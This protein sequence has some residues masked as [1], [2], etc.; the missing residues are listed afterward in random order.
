MKTSTLLF[1]SLVLTSVLLG[2]NVVS[3]QTYT[4]SNRIPLADKTLGTQVSGSNSNFNI[5]GGLQR[6][7][8]LFHSFGDFSVPTSGQ[9]NFINP[10]GNR[11]IITRVTG[12][13]FSDINGTV[14]TQGANFFLINPNGLVFGPNAQLNV[15]KAFVGSTANGIDLVDG[16]GRTVTFGTNPNGDAPLLS[17][18]PNVFFNVSRLNMGGGN[19]AISNFG[20][21]QTTNPNQYIGLIGGRVTMNGG[22]IEAPGGRVE[23]GGLSAPGTIGIGVEGN[24]LRLNFPTNIA[25]GDVFFSNQARVS[26][27]GAGGGDIAITARNLGILSGS[28]VRAGIETGL[29]TPEAVAG[30]I[31]LNATGDIVVAGSGSA[32]ANNVR[33]NSKGTGGNIAIDTNSLLL[34][35]GG[36]FQIVT[37]GRGNAGNLT[38]TAKNVVALDNARIDTAI[39]PEGVGTAGNIKIDAASLS[40][41]NGGVLSSS[42]LGQGKAGNVEV[43]VTGAMNVRGSGIE[44]PSGITSI[45]AEKG[46]G[47]AG[48]IKIEAA[49]LSLRDAGALSSSSFGQGNA[50][51]VDVKVSGAVDIAGTTS[52]MSSSTGTGVIG[53][54]GYLSINAGSLSLRNGAFLLASTLG[55]GNAGNVTVTAKDA[56]SLTDRANISSAVR[57]GG[58]GKGGSITINSAALSLNNGSRISASTAGQGDAGNLSITAKDAVVLT[59]RGTISS[60]VDAGGVGKGGRITINSASLLLKNGAQIRASTAGAA[61]KQPAARGAAGD[62][63]IKVAG[64]IDISGEKDGFN[65]EIRSTVG[66]GAIG[67]GGNITVNAGS[68]SLRDSAFLLT[69]TLGKGNAGNIDVKVAGVVDLKGRSAFG[70][71]VGTKA[72]GN[73]GNITVDAGSIS[74][75]GSQLAVSTFGQGNAGNITVTA[76]GDISLEDSSILSAVDAGGMGKGGNITLKAGSLSLNRSQLQTLTKEATNTQPAGRGDAGNVNIQVTRGVDIAGANSGII[77]G[78]RIGTEG[79]GGDITVDAGSFS[80]RDLA[81]LSATTLAQGNAGKIRV[82]ASDSVTISGTSSLNSASFIGTGAAGD[83][84]VISPKITLDA[85]GFIFTNSDSG[86]G[87]NINIGSNI[88]PTDLLILRR[89][90]GISTDAGGTARQGG[91]GGNININSNLIVAI[92]NE[93]SDITANAVKGKGGNVNI[94]S[95]GLFGIQYSPLQTDNSDITA[96]SDFGQSGNVNISTPGTDPGKDKGELTAAPNDASKQISQACSASQR[97]NKFYIIG[98]GGHPANAEDPLTSDVVWLDPRGAKPQPVVS[99]SSQTTRKLAPPAV[100]WVFDGKGK[101]TLIAAQTEGAP[102]KTRVVCPQERK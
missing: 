61:G 2:P 15:G 60:G 38:V 19:G 67:N 17:I 32:I 68:L 7:Q 99:V 88:T 73:G 8:T 53:N 28:V 64:A 54:G 101:V 75:N 34:Q 77:S 10:V 24:N 25:R 6:G 59:D 69:T 80:L 31:K 56:V 81:Q 23:L 51:N 72:I 33:T 90:A 63:N 83:I 1:A 21:L 12:N 91:N 46:V 48:S 94:K 26:V 92:P 16:G 30:D 79:N 98:R 18:N 43:K 102:T 84:I 42:T 13:L 40:L 35:D 47:T 52:F 82:N 89:G 95:Q 9:A 45:V 76:K 55:Q 49:S 39:Q 93:N 96:S 70:S 14:N 20:T 44:S 100:G 3:A 4:P 74:F 5:T 37:F 97:D 27:A 36:A 66:T 22:K 29:G 50:G 87:G 58:V 65:S 78:V 85:G 62:I 11:D 41:F 57:A 86:N 71:P